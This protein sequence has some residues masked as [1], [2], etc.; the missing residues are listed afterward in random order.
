T[1]SSTCLDLSCERGN[2]VRAKRRSMKRCGG[3]TAEGVRYLFG[4]N[5]TCFGERLTAQK[6]CQQGTR[7]NRGNA[8]LR[9]EARPDEAPWLEPHSQAQYVTADRIRHLD[10]SGSI[11]KVPGVV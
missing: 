1:E 5:S 2:H 10:R 7:C 9:L 6:V 3:Q 4:R 8:P 11:R